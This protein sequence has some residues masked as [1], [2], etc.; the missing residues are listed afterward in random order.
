MAKLNTLKAIEEARRKINYNYDM[1]IEDIMAID[2][3]SDEKIDL[4]CKCF[5]FGYVQGAKAQKKGCA[6]NE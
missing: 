3:T 4:I 1:T 6:F 2:E 5:T